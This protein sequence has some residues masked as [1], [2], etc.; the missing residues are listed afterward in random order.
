MSIL[1]AG[2]GIA[3]VVGVG[4]KI[5]KNQQTRNSN[6]TIDKGFYA[7]HQNVCEKYNLLLSNIGNA[8]NLQSYKDMISQIFIELVELDKKC[9]FLKNK[10]AKLRNV[11]NS[12]LEEARNTDA[13]PDRLKKNSELTIQVENEGNSLV[14]YVKKATKEIDETAID[15]VNLNA[16]IELH[17][18]KT[19]FDFSKLK[20]KVDNLRFIQEHIP[21]SDINEKHY[22]SLL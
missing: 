21:M 8:R 11:R 6:Y 16:E 10:F 5:I 12:L 18:D 22:C 14:D 17:K 9:E 2:L 15:F 20:S 3:V 4:Y 1:L 19:D 7:R 13:N